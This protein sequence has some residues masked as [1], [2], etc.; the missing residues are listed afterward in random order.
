MDSNDTRSEAE[1]NGFSIGAMT[2]PVEQLSYYVMVFGVLEP[3]MPDPSEGYPVAACEP[4]S[5]ACISIELGRA[6]ANLGLE[7]VFANTFSAP[8]VPRA[9]LMSI[10]GVWAGMSKSD[11]ATLR[12]L[13]PSLA[14]A[15]ELIAPRVN[16]E[17]GGVDGNPQDSE[18]P[19]TTVEKEC[20]HDGPA[21]CE[22]D[23]DLWDV[24]QER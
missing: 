12:L 14:Q 11:K 21:C 19:P 15:I 24:D 7:P 10:H 18:H 13:S 16:Y 3:V 9:D 22:A 6:F 20:K 1:I 23:D 8:I 5:T 4:V 2:A 17:D